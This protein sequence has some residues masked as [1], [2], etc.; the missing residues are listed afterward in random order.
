MTECWL[1]S[2]PINLVYLHLQMFDTIPISLHL[3]IQQFA[4]HLV[5]EEC[6]IGMG[7]MKF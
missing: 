7:E 3:Q 4:I 5:K 2:H 1:S 6:R